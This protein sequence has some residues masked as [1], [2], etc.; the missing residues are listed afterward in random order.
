MV[1][2]IIGS[3]AGGIA[4]F[5]VTFLFWW[6]PLSRLAFK[7]V[8][9]GANADLQAALARNLTASGTGT[10]A[11]PWTGTQQGTTL[12]GQGPIAT[13][14]FNV[15]GFA[16]S[17]SGA[18]LGGL[19]LSIIV[20]ALIALALHGIATRVTSWADRARLVVLFAVAAALWLHLSQPLL[21]HADWGYFVYLAIGDALGFAA[22]GLVI[23]RWFLPPPRLEP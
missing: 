6:T 8:G 16:V 22:A 19:I 17:D 21:H 3:I 1:R 4:Q 23:A 10:Y 15:H 2:L 14:H 13:V 18:L 5:L 7:V 11:V 12:Y 9:D 20:A